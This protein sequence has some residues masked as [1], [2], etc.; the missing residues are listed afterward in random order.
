[1]PSS[2]K[3]FSDLLT[4][5]KLQTK[6]NKKYNLALVAQ[7]IFDLLYQSYTGRLLDFFA[8]QCKL[9]TTYLPQEI[10][11]MYMYIICMNSNLT[12]PECVLNIRIYICLL[13]KIRWF[14]FTCTQTFVCAIYSTFVAFINQTAQ[15]VAISCEGE[16]SY[17]CVFTS[18]LWFN[19]MT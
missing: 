2:Y 8:F 19:K 17:A 6:Q 5:F 7:S 14:P 10:I 13:M 9:A 3:I 4:F 15:L 1:M 11:H 18:Y 12:Y 16:F